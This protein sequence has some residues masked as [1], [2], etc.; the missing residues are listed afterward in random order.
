MA[1]A[2]EGGVS[3]TFPKGV[4][5]NPEMELCRDICSLLVGALPEKVSVVDAMCA[6]GV[7]GI[8]YKKENK[9]VGKLALCDRSGRAIACARENAAKNGV[10]CRVVHADANDFLRKNQFDFVELDPFGSPAPFL[11][12]AA[13]CLS[14]LKKGY[15]SATATD[16]AVLCGAEHPAC[17][18]NY[19]AAPLDNEFCHENAARILLGKVALTCAGFS[20]AAKPIFTLSHRHYLKVVLRAERSAKG[21][22]DAVKSLGFVS[23]CP[24]CCF[25]EARRNALKEKCPHCGHA[26]VHAGPLFLGEL[27]SPALLER[28]LGLSA[29]RGYRKSREIDKILRTI[30]SESAIPAYAYYDLHKLAK[31]NRGRIMGMEEALSALWKAGFAASRTH[32]CPTAIRTDAPHEKVLE[33]LC[34][35]ADDEGQRTQCSI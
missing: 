9:N 10:R 19:G 28:M 15:L 2:K 12:D 23:Y 14:G 24:G 4:F 18:R 20:L 29:E 16:M 31:K 21:A 26:L 13:R 25:R 17:L 35:S 8:R 3:V 22:A 5:Y 30:L 11:H 33:A 27:W 6:S 32:F 1:N 7:R 34:L